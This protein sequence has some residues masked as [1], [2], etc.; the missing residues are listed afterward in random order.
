MTSNFRIDLAAESDLADVAA[1]VNL[2]YRGD[3]A[4]QGWTSEAGLVQGL[5]T[6]EAIVR[7]DLA[8]KPASVILTMR[9]VADGILLGCV[10][11]EP[12][13]SQKWFLGMLTIRP[14]TQGRQLGRTLLAAAEAHAIERGAKTMRMTVIDVR[15][16]L[17]A[18]YERRGYVLLEE[19]LPFNY[20][21]P[22]ATHLRFAVL[23][24]VLVPA[25]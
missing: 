3:S 1:L 2:A 19:T 6:S 4:R 12:V 11:L 22:P 21:D 8:A 7:G 14:D 25:R 17:I 13:D 20:G 9:D 5:R 16:T 24:K 18:W 10:W 23:E 15:D